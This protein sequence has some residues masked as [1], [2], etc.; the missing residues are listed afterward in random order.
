MEV[1]EVDVRAADFVTAE[2]AI[3]GG[4]QSRTAKN[5][6]VYRSVQLILNGAVRTYEIS[7]EFDGELPEPG[8]KVYV[9]FMAY[10]IT[11]QARSR[12]G[13]EYTRRVESLAVMGL[14]AAK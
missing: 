8:Q 11:T 1:V 5:G 14:K 2:P 13:V 4:I 10:G 7:R 9:D 3:F 12:D 6:N